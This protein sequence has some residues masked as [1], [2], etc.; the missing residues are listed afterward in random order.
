MATLPKIITYEEWLDMPVTPKH[1][2]TVQIEIAEIW[3][4]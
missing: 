2:P 1:F 3:P 4:D